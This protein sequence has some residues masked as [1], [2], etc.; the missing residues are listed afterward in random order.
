M[1]RPQSAED[2]LRDLA[3]NTPKEIDLEEIAFC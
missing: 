2:I 3:I 1:H